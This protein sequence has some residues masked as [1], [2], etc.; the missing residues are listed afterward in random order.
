MNKSE[1]YKSLRKCIQNKTDVVDAVYC[2][3]L[4]AYITLI[5]GKKGI[6]SKKSYKGGFGIAKIIDKRDWER[7]KNKNLPTGLSTAKKL[8]DAVEKGKIRRYV[9]TTKRYF[10]Y[11]NKY[12]AVISV[13]Y[14]NKELRW[15]LTGYKIN[16]SME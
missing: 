13:E 15:L 12:E 7:I 2:K 6:A 5:Y 9:P 4:K 14:K 1:K 8:I 3:S 11:Y 10:I 16:A